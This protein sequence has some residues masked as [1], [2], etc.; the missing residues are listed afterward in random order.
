V[1]G[2]PFDRISDLMAVL[3]KTTAHGAAALKRNK[4]RGKNMNL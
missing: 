3:L 4:T 2:F 1:S